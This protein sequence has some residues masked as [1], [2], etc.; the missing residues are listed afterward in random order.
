V[1]R[2]QSARLQDP[3]NQI[4]MV[5]ERI[6]ML[7]ST[8]R[9]GGQE[10]GQALPELNLALGSAYL[11]QGALDDAEREYLAAIK[12]NPKLGAAHNNLAVIYM[13][14]ERFPAAHDALRKAE[15]AGFAVSPNLKRDLEAREKAASAKP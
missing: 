10:Q 13:L 14:S 4:M 2:L 15:K 3:G 9:K 12:A 7:E 11:R 8:R 6:R 5:E 1:R